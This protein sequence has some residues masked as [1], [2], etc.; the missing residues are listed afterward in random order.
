MTFSKNKTRNQRSKGASYIIILIGLS[1]LFSSCNKDLVVIRYQHLANFQHWN[2]AGVQGEDPIGRIGHVYMLKDISN[3]DKNAKAFKFLI[4]KFHVGEATLL[5]AAQA[6]AAAK[7]F[8]MQT[9]FET[10][11]AAGTIFSI[12]GSNAKL[13]FISDDNTNT[14]KTEVVAIKYYNEKNESVLIL[15][16]KTKTSVPFGVLDKA[17][18]DNILEL[19][20]EMEKAP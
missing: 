3:N 4:E 19:Q 5:S 7:P 15:P 17:F 10:D 14:G 2:F 9:N 12:P 6:N 1:F 18:L 8:T 11:I 16:V 20:K 13:F